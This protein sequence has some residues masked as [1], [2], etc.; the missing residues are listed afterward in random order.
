[1]VHA[2]FQAAHE[3]TAD[4]ILAAVKKV[5]ADKGATKVVSVGHSLGG[6]LAWLEGLHLKLNLPSGVNVVTRTFGQP[7]VR[8]TCLFE[9][10]YTTD[11]GW[12]RL[13]MP[14]FLSLW[15]KRSVS[16]TRRF[17]SVLIWGA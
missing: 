6:A 10:R 1:M 15:I 3:R 16:F 7:R 12:S 9:A 8:F 2:G 5:I 17:G 14:S 4:V 13:E 11:L